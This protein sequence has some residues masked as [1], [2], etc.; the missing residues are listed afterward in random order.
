[1]IREDFLRVVVFKLILSIRRVSK[2]RKGRKRIPGEKT[3]DQR[4]RDIR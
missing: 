1:M 4:P 2:A 3:S